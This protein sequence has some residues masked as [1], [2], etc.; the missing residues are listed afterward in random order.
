M[1]KNRHID[2][3]KQLS[4]LFLFLYLFAGI[5]HMKG[6]DPLTWSSG[7]NCKNFLSYTVQQ[8]EDTKD[9]YNCIQIT[10]GIHDL[11]DLFD[12]TESTVKQIDTD[13]TQLKN[14]YST[15]R[16]QAI[17]SKTCKLDFILSFKPQFIQSVSLFLFIRNILI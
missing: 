5:I 12:K 11:S 15:D 4:F 10:S 17:K 16:K 9:E 7:I 13:K 3:I 2:S 14:I 8:R 1:L 6:N